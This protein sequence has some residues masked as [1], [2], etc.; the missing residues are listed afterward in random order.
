MAFC[1]N[2]GASLEEGKKFCPGCGTA[3]DSAPNNSS[4]NQANSAGPNVDFSDKISNIANTEDKTAECDAQDI[5]N[6]KVM[7]ILAY[8]GI[9]VLIPIFAA[10]ESK[11]ARF[12]ANQGLVLF[13]AEIIW[14]I[15]YGIIS[16]ILTFALSILGTVISG[17]LGLVSLGFLALLI[18]GIVNAATG[19]AKALPIIGKIILIK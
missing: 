11:F 17:I 15:V 5:S 10:P 8:I 7:A 2:C 16:A 4:A 14:G 18:I 9:L 1:K 12:H 19:K 13:I 3:V 6:N